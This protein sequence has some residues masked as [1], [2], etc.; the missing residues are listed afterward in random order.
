MRKWML[1]L[2]LCLVGCMQT[3]LNNAER[4]MNHPQFP[5]AAKAAPEFTADALKTINAL[6]EQ[7]EAQP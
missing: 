2:L 5:T 6:E 7:L 1:A 3:K 4:L